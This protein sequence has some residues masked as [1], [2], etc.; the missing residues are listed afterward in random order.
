MANNTKRG[1]NTKPLAIIKDTGDATPGDDG[2]E[3]SPTF[4]TSTGTQKAR[5]LNFPVA[6]RPNAR[7]C[8][9]TGRRRVRR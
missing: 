9:R 7:R 4:G 6:R 1:A 2:S 3:A 5:V 8:D